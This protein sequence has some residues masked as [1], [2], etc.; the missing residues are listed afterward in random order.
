MKGCLFVC[1]QAPPL[2]NRL[3]V[4]YPRKNVSFTPEIVIPSY[5]DIRYIALAP[6]DK[7]NRITIGALS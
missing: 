2:R 6:C 4:A 1:G 3:I 7:K 5:I